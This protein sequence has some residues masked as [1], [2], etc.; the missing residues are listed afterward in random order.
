VEGHGGGWTT[1]SHGRVAESEEA[2]LKLF[3][4]AAL[5]HQVFDPLDAGLGEA[6]ALWVADRGQL[7]DDLLESQNSLNCS[8]NCGPPSEPIDFGQPNSL[9]QEERI[10]TMLDVVA[11]RRP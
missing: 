8:L 11:V 2:S 7:M 3:F 1:V 6:V 9:N 4:S 5:L 10:L